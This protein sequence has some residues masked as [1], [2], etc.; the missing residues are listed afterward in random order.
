MAQLKFLAAVI[1][2]VGNLQLDN[3]LPG[4]IYSLNP[5][6]R[7]IRLLLQ[8][9]ATVDLK[10]VQDSAKS[11]R[12]ICVPGNI[13]AAKVSVLQT[14]LDVKMFKKCTLFVQHY[15]YYYY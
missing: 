10:H 15:Y 2:F 6:H 5:R 1:S 4:P 14:Y 12:K 7:W 8:L 11:F 13:F 9:T 3:L